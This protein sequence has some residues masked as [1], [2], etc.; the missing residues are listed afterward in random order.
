MSDAVGP[1]SLGFLILTAL[2]LGLDAVRARRLVRGL[3]RDAAERQRERL[4]EAAEHRQAAEALRDSEARFR[5]LFE[6]GLGF[7][8][9]HDLEGRLLN[10]NPAAA[11]ALGFTVEELTGTNLRDLLAPAVRAGFSAYLDGLRQGRSAGGTTADGADGLMRLLTRTGEERVWMYRNAVQTS[12]SEPPYVLGFAF[13]VTASRAA[14]EALVA[15]ER[16]RH[17]HLEQIQQQNLELEIRHQEAVRANRLKSEF[18][19]TMSHELRTP[20]NAI[21]GFSELLA[22]DPATPLRGQQGFHLGFVRQAAEH[23]L[24]LIDDILDLSKIEAGRLKLTPERLL[25]AG[26]LPEVLSTLAP[27]AAQKRIALGQRVPDDLSVFADRLHL[28]Q[29]L[30]NLL[31]NAVKFTPPEGTITVMGT[32][33]KGYSL[34][35]VG[36]TGSAIDPGEQEGIFD[37][38][39]QARQ[40]AAVHGG[41]GLGLAI[42][43]RLVEQHGGKVWVESSPGTGTTFVVL[44][45]DPSDLLAAAPPPGP[46][47]PRAQRATGEAAILLV[48]DDAEASG[49][50][51]EAL[52]RQRFT[53]RTAG[54][55]GEVLPWIQRAEPQ[56]TILDLASTGWRGARLLNALQADGDAP[57]PLILAIVSDPAGRRPALL[58][59]AHGCLA[60]PFDDGLLVE[61]C[62]RRIEPLDPPRVVLI[63]EADPELQRLLTELTIGAGFRPV[64][65]GGGGDALQTAD[66]IRP[67]AVVLDLDLPGLDGYQTIVRLRS[68]PAT[69][70]LPV[71]VLARRGADA[72][73]TQAFSGPTRLLWLPEGDWRDFGAEIQRTVDAERW[74][75][76]VA[77]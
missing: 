22:E 52:R 76:P 75:L 68:N 42:V 33:E 62:R 11:G 5:N 67:H 61:A 32:R 60:L 40:G 47:L 15:S 37:E 30:F 34:L 71:L 28:K 70:N 27:L 56:L 50:W 1:L 19:A 66:H 44:L 2:V 69:A 9:I 53:V 26:L 17:G 18:L 21:L 73:E 24:R 57:P 6:N 12:P 59:G 63:V 46:S 77:S 41:W 49:R 54:C 64:V 3:R 43:R 39:Q 48:S 58:A 16:R 35:S 38:F 25:V 10:V 8:C 72:V 55:D 29:I 4:A 14:S 7:V 45:P 31:S 23:L 20:L 13:D 51:A 74:R 65:V 36:N